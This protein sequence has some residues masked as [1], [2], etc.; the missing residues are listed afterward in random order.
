MF[1]GKKIQKQILEKQ[2]KRIGNLSHAPLLSIFY[3]GNNPVIEQYI[4]VKKRYGKK[5]GVKVEVIHFPENTSEEKVKESLLRV[6]NPCIIQLPL[7]D[8][9][10][11]EN[12]LSCVPEEYDIDILS[13]LA[14]D[15]FIHN[16]TEFVPPVARAVMDI[17]RE[18]SISLEN[19]KV[20]IIGKG[21]LVGLQIARLFD[22][23]GIS[24]T[25]IDH[26]DNLLD[27]VRDADII[28]SGT[29]VPSLIKGNDI[30]EGCILIDA[31]TTSDGVSIV[32][33]FD[34]S[35][36]E[37][38]YGYTPVPGGIGPLTV[39]SLF[40]NVVLYYERNV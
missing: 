31:G 9:F 27:E 7:P 1:D 30:K 36:Y 15:S 17:V 34:S 24:Y 13:S 4:E 6:G 18:Y 26:T 16:N 33:D 35:T 38:A 10:S 28:I 5:I 40:E 8:I 19:K 20:L 22:R 14:I 32:G 25:I 23:D 2:K 39:S 11:K 12:I 3:I 37:K 29:G 21:P